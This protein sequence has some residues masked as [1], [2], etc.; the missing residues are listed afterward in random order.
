MA[1][2]IAAEMP[3]NQAQTIAGLSILGIG[4]F[5]FLSN[6]VKFKVFHRIKDGGG[7]PIL[8]SIVPTN[9][10]EVVKILRIKKTGPVLVICTMVMIGLMLTV[11][12]SLIIPNTINI[13]ESCKPVNVTT[14]AQILNE[15]VGATLWAYF[16]VEEMRLR[17]M[18]SG[19]PDDVLAGQ[20]PNDTRWKFNSQLDVDPYPWRTSCSLYNS[21]TT[22]VTM[23]TSV[24]S[25]TAELDKALPEVH[26][27]FIFKNSPEGYEFIDSR[28]ISFMYDN[29]NNNIK[30]HIGALIIMKEAF[31]NGN[32]SG[33]GGK[34]LD[35][36]WTLRVPETTKILANGPEVI[37]VPIV[38]KAYSCE[39]ERVKEGDH[40][41]VFLLEGDGTVGILETI[42]NLIANKWWLAI[43]NGED[44]SSN[45]FTPDYW[46]SF[47]SV[48]GSRKPQVE[49]ILAQINMSCI[50]VHTTYILLVCLYIILII[51][52][53]ICW[54]TTQTK[55]FEIPSSSVEWASLACKESTINNDNPSKILTKQAKLGVVSNDIKILSKNDQFP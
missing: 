53:F 40:G 1:I 34:F 41:S 16:E 4:W 11:F 15:R 9:M 51:I 29:F 42:G 27:E 46:A 14:Q 5:I 37:T 23:N 33:I 47:L 2:E 10:I 43:S 24:L 39:M 52:G 3:L 26:E 8:E 55:D 45:E 19:V 6:V 36:L 50:R 12:D 38:V 13:N 28:Y 30:E 35:R 20:I 32:V 25:A 49:E 21:G 44:T 18:K 54:F 48:Q 31:F 7:L 17:R 22:K